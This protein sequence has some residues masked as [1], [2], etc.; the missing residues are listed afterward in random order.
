MKFVVV[1]G[2][3]CG[4]APQGP[5]VAPA[6]RPAPV[7]VVAP[8]GDGVDDAGAETPS[9]AATDVTAARSQQKLE[10]RWE[11]AWNLHYGGNAGAE[12]E[13]SLGSVT[14]E[15]G[16]GGRSKAVDGGKR[17]ESIL[18]G[19]RYTEKSTEWRT[20]W[21]GT[22]ALGKGRLSLDLVRDEASCVLTE[23]E[24]Q[25]AQQYLPSKTVCSAGVDHLVLDCEEQSVGAAPA[26]DDLAT[27]PTPTPAWDCHPAGA[28][29]VGVGTAFPWVFGKRQCLE[30]TGGAPRSGPLRYAYCKL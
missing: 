23:T 15:L 18:D 26:L 10:L 8:A 11:N 14:I 22:W 16:A 2:F 30:R 7:T 28:V 25:G 17:E 5:S 3:I 12:H 19:N 1:C 24:R 13:N 27:Q 9:D 21:R 4:C 20:T 6:A 29:T